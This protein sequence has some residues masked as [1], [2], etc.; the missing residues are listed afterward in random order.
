ML[1]GVQPEKVSERSGIATL[2]VYL[3]NTLFAA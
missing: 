1:K 3:L 2:L